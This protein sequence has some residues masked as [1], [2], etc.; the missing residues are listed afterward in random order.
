MTCSSEVVRDT[1]PES[2][3]R[4]ETLTFVIRSGVV[5][6]VCGGNGRLDSCKRFRNFDWEGIV[7]MTGKDS[8]RR[9]SVVVVTA[10]ARA[11]T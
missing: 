2:V 4:V 8:V 1:S 7:D 5:L 6:D 9:G 10:S 3:S 11:A